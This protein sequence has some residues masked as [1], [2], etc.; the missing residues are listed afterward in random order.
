MLKI[1]TLKYSSAWGQEDKQ[2]SAETK[3]DCEQKQPGVTQGSNRLNTNAL[4]ADEWNQNGE[5]ED[6]GLTALKSFWGFV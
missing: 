6:S 5:K 4:I 3:E 1:W 2:K